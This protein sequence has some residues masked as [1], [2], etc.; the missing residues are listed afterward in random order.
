MNKSSVAMRCNSCGQVFGKVAIKKHLERCVVKEGK[1]NAAD[2]IVF[3]IRV[4]G[5]Y[6]KEYCMYLDI[7]ANA[8]LN[9]LD[10]FLR[11]TWLE[12]C[13]HLSMF[14]IGG[15]IY[16]SAPDLNDGFYESHSMN[17]KLK[18]VL[19]EGL[20]FVHEYDFGSTTVLKLK[21]LSERVQPRRRGKII[22]MARNLPPV[23]ECVQCGKPAT[24]LCC[25]CYEVD[26]QFC[27]ECGE[28]HPCGEEMML[29]VVNSPRM[30]VC[31]Y[32]D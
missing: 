9:D 8:S 26:A 4:Q 22:L 10:Q 7:S 31:A 11:D 27:D 25:E 1:G 18:N 28:D 24:Q 15:D 19:Y 3:W 14:K 17:A 13:G 6:Q 21:V 30:G 2:T 23:I 12:C 29:P 20:E 5:Y 32:G 16:D